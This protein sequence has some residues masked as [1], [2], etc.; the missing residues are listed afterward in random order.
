MDLD[1]CLLENKPIV[2][3]G[4]NTQDFKTKVEV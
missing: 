2:P 3:T 4:E 1:I